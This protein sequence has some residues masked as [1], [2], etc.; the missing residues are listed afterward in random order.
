MRYFCTLHRWDLESQPCAQCADEQGE[1]EDRV[2]RAIVA[3]VSGDVSKL[4]ELYISTVVGEGPA[5]AARSRDQLAI[6]IAA[7]RGALS[8]ERVTFGSVQ[9]RG[10]LVRVEWEASALHVGP[11]A[12]E[13]PG[14]VLEPTGLRLRVR[15][16]T[17][18]R[19]RGRRIASWRSHWEDLAFAS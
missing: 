14:A 2:R 13:G 10:A 7:R 16:V 3:A 19:F 15:V 11:L 8:Q 5:T 17:V 12:L 1:R 18:A 6:E 4:E 9:S